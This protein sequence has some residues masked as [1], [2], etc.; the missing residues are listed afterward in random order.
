VLPEKV[1]GKKGRETA[2]R[3]ITGENEVP[4]YH[5]EKGLPIHQSGE[6]ERKRGSY[7]RR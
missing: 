6:G 3:N 1:Q 5:E 4:A 7:L 2:V